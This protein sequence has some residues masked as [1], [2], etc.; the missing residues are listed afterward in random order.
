MN[1]TN[2]ITVNTDGKWNL[3]TNTLPENSVVLGTVTRNGYD[4]GALVRMNGTGAY[5][6][7]NAGAIRSLNKIAVAKAIYK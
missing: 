7:V 5:V 6:Q 4:T 2:N 1:Q 3:Y